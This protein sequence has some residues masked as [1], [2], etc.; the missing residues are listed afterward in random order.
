MDIDFSFNFGADFSRFDASGYDSSTTGSYEYDSISFDFSVEDYVAGRRRRRRRRRPRRPNRQLRFQSVLTSC[1]YVNFLKPGQTRDMAHE[2]SSSDRFGEFRHWFR[3]SLAKVEELTRT[4]IARGYIRRPRSLV[5]RAEF[6][7]RAELLVMSALY[8]L[9]HGAAFRSVRALTHICMSDIHKF[10][11][12]FLD[13][14]MEMRGE[15]ISLPENIAELNRITRC[16]E[17]CG[18]P[19]ACG[20]MDVV[21]IKWSACPT[22]DLNRAKG[23]EGYPTV[24]FQCITDFNRRILGVYGPQFG[25][26]ND[27]HIVKID[28]NVREIRKGWMKDVVWRYFTAEGEVREERGMYLI[29]DNGYLRWPQSI[30]PYEG[31]NK[32]T[33]E[34]Y[35]STNLESVRK[36]VECTF[37]IL[38]KRWRILNNGLN[39][40][41]IGKCEK[42]F[43]ACAC[44][45]NF[46]LDQMERTD[47]RVGRGYP[48][49]DDG[50][51]LSGHTTVDT[52][53]TEKFLATQFGRRR[54][55][56]ARH[57]CVFRKKGQIPV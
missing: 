4:L 16:Y 40:R 8:I 28:Q 42:I 35:F 5:R 55:L 54:A 29:C 10:F 31:A 37:G 52:T 48:I 36:D 18:L 33:L 53:E 7:E 2:L 13:A 3:M 39:Y 21:H 51:W 30:C 24:A 12:V 6:F 46:L 45:H 34:G 14:F 32:A 47:V 38:K 1:W 25:T 41:D 43:V 57:L 49:G 20:S 44:L 26:F 27:K 17:A 50:L 19:G 9:G 23:K 22:G 11:F 15:Y 56:L